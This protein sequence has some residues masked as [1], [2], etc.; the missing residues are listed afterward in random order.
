[1]VCFFSLELLIVVGCTLLF[2]VLIDLRALIDLS[3]LIL[4]FLF[5]SNLFCFFT[6]NPKLI[7]SYLLF[8][9]RFGDFLG[10]V[11]GDFFELLALRAYFPTNNNLEFINN[12]VYIII[13]F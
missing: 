3:V 9:L 5:D 12:I 1:M 8:D 7:S 13:K 6:T 2:N 11:F 4:S 10:D